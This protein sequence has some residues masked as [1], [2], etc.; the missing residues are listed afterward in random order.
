MSRN[1]L[2]SGRFVGHGSFRFGSGSGGGSRVHRG[3]GDDLSRRFSRLSVGGERSTRSI[4][5]PSIPDYAFG[6]EAV[7][8]ASVEIGEIVPAP[9]PIP[10]NYSSTR[11]YLKVMWVSR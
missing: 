11:E 10:E 6:G 3:S 5:I 7:A 9:K 8:G 1:R 4:S 2:S